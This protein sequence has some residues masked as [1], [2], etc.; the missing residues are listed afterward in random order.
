MRASWWGWDAGSSLFF[1]RWPSEFRKEA[2]DGTP[3]RISGSL[4]MYCKLQQEEKE[5]LK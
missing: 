5:P 3:V 2:R 1:W 4:P